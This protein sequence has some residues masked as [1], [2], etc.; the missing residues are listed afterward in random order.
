MASGL[1]NPSLMK[2]QRTKTAPAKASTVAGQTE[3]NLLNCRYAPRFLVRGMKSSG[4][5]KG[6][7]IIHF[8]RT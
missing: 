5:G 7:N 3:F 8:H 2:G 6:I 1:N 4:V